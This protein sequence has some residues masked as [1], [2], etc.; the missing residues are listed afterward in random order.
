MNLR[1]ASLL[2]E[3]DG[4]PLHLVL[5]Y[6]SAKPSSDAKKTSHGMT[7]RLVRRNGFGSSNEAPSD[8]TRGVISVHGFACPS[9]V[10]KTNSGPFSRADRSRRTL[11]SSVEQDSLLVLD[12]LYEDFSAIVFRAT[13]DRAVVGDRTHA[14]ESL[15]ANAIGGHAARDEKFSDRVGAPLR[16]LLARSGVAL[17]IGEALDDDLVTVGTFQCVGDELELAAWR[18]RR[19]VCDEELVRGQANHGSTLFDAHASD[20]HDCDLLERLA[21]LLLRRDGRWYH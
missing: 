13:R 14:S 1:M 20:A 10:V 8:R 17:R 9:H 12:R 16:E 2:A 18:D 4:S 3:A 6:A 5:P 15:R 21:C 7:R 19:R 11:S